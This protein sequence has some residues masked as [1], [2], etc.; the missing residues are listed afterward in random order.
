MSKHFVPLMRSYVDVLT[1]L[2]PDDPVYYAARAAADAAG[3]APLFSEDTPLVL[4]MSME[5]RAREF[6]HH[7]NNSCP[8]SGTIPTNLARR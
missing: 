4:A 1:I 6:W 8:T 7:S 3:G 5:A 2:R